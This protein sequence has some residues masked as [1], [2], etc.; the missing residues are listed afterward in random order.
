MKTCLAVLVML[1]GLGPA[2]ANALTVYF[3]D[4][5][6][7]AP[8]V[9]GDPSDPTDADP[10]AQVGSYGSYREDAGTVGVQTTDWGTPGAAGGN[11]Y[12][13]M[14]APG[15]GIQSVRCDT[16]A[17]TPTGEPV[18]V[19]LD[20]YAPS[21]NNCAGWIYVHGTPDYAALLYLGKYGTYNNIYPGTSDHYFEGC[22]FSRDV[23]NHL[24][25]YVDFDTETYRISLNGIVSPR[26]EPFIW[27]GHPTAIDSISLLSNRTPSA[28]EYAYW[29]NVEISDAPRPSIANGVYFWD[30]FESALAVAGDKTDATDADPGMA[31]VGRWDV[32]EGAAD[33]V[34]VT[35]WADPGAAGGSNYL[36]MH[37]PDWSPVRW[38]HARTAETTPAGRNVTVKFDFY[39]YGYD[40]PSPYAKGRLYIKGW[41]GVCTWLI[42]GEAHPYRIYPVGDYSRYFEDATWTFPQWNSVEINLDMAA[43]TYTVACNGVTSPRVEPFYDANADD[44][45]T[46]EFQMSYQ[47]VEGKYFYWDNVEVTAAPVS[48]PGTVLL[49]Q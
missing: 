1:L 43:K 26:V 7:T 36:R 31:V 25:I 45:Y 46:V 18:T 16:S 30:D 5:F 37:G 15:S 49:V 22:T 24:E 8:E 4:D 21:G 41:S 44:V 11:N 48:P 6:E 40:D 38:A 27:D 9:A 35:D 32:T 29:D 39:A 34:Q 10:V 23:W 33:D 47:P 3:Q 2:A 20:F 13:R 12:L 14:Y 19:K 28:N 17:P 42:F